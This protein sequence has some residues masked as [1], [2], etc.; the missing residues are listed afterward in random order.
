MY[1]AACVAALA[2]AWTLLALRVDPVPAWFYVFAWYPTLGLFDA[3][4]SRRAGERPLVR[5]PRPALS[6][7]LWSA[8]IWLLFE[9]ANFRLRNWYY[10][11]LPAHPVERWAGILI[12]FATVVPAVVLAERMLRSLG[13]GDGWRGA[14]LR[15]TPRRLATVCGLGVVTT[16]LALARPAEGFALI[17]GA[18]WLLADPLVYRRRPE[19]SLLGDLERGRWGRIGRL[20]VGGVLIGVIW[21]AYNGWAR[22]KW[23][24]TVPWLEQLKWFEMPPLGFLGFPFLALE[25]WAVYHLLC[26]VG[27]AV[28]VDERAGR[29]AR[30]DDGAGRGARGLEA[31]PLPPRPVLRAP[32]RV[33]AV[34]AAALFSALTLLGMERWTI[35]SMTPRLRDLPGITSAEADALRAAGVSTPFALA[36]AETVEGAGRTGI[37]PE[38]LNALRGLAA[39]ATLR[40]IGTAHTRR[41]VTLGIDDPC[42]LARADADALWRALGGGENARPT[43]AE[44]RVWVRASRAFAERRGSHNDCRSAIADRRLQI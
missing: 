3:V 29:G 42:A 33:A 32:R 27:V 20:L 41:L 30:G 18:L 21:E 35:S 25:A 17:W 28:P 23:I 44:V 5:R 10:V 39:L 12:S 13:V 24:Y 4:A 31:A 16:A 34:L 15:V 38:R 7:L 40:G 36:D 9:A 14:P 22:G 26:A 1:A 2:A 11:F 19:W 6:L 8:P 43:A 37:P